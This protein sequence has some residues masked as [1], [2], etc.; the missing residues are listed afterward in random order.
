M[1]LLPTVGYPRRRKEIAILAATYIVF[2][3]TN[4]VTKTEMN[5]NLTSWPL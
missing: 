5:I 2:I 3:I 4:T 1:R